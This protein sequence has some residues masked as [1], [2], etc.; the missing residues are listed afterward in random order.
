MASII[1]WIP[2]LMLPLEAIAM[3]HLLS[4]QTDSVRDHKLHSGYVICCGHTAIFL[5]HKLSKTSKWL[6]ILARNLIFQYDRTFAAQHFYSINTSKSFVFWKNWAE[7]YA[8]SYS[9]NT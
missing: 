9:I 8:Q 6:T 7:F 5:L 1:N 3:P 2:L 4:R